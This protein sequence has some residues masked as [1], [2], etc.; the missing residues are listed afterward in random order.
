MEDWRRWWLNDLSTQ[1]C[2]FSTRR[3]RSD[4]IACLTVSSK[5]LR[6]A[7]QTQASR[8][9]ACKTFGPVDF[10]QMP[11]FIWAEEDHDLTCSTCLPAVPGKAVR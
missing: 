4:S 10:A 5:A 9:M 2:A 8:L 11:L 6:A 1:G 3:Y 7:P